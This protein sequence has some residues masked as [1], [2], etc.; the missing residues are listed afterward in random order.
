MITAYARVMRRTRPDG[1][2]L[3]FT[4]FRTVKGYGWVKNP[5]GSRFAHRIVWVHHHGPT[6]L[7]VLHRCDNPPCV[8]LDHL[9]T[10]THA[11]NMADMVAKGRS[12][13]GERNGKT[14]L[15]DA[16]ISGIRQRRATGELRQTIAADFGITPGYVSDLATGR[17][18]A[19]APVRHA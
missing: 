18:R 15:T 12:A 7:R 1:D 6:A 19:D 2:C 8:K 3:V 9:F 14:K 16:Q 17:R 10:G 13:L 11:D 4:G 5:D